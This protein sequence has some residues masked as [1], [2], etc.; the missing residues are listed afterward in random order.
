MTERAT[1]TARVLW[2]CTAFL[3][4]VLPIFLPSSPNPSGFPS[5]TISISTGVMYVL[6]FPGGLLSLLLS[7]IVDLAFGIDPDSIQGMYLN[8]KLTFVLGL[9]QWFWFVP[10]SL[11]GM[12]RGKAFSS[13]APPVWALSD[14]S[15]NDNAAF[16]VDQERSPLERIFDE[17]DR[18]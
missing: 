4:L 18:P 3:S 6:S 5:D 13:S 12:A 2:L 11:R 10:K 7:P 14:R 1:L 16:I 17:A 15:I 9:A 8:L